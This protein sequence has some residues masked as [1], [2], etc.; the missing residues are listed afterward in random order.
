VALIMRPTDVREATGHRL[1]MA[2]RGPPPAD[3]PATVASD[4]ETGVARMQRAL[5]VEEDRRAGRRARRQEKRE[6]RRR[7]RSPRSAVGLLIGAAVLTVVVVNGAPYWLMLIAIW[8]AVMAGSRLLGSRGEASGEVVDADATT[9]DA[10]MERVDAL[11]D[12]LL[13][14]IRSAP[15]VLREV[16]HRPEETV[17]A[18]RDG[19]HALERRERELRNLLRPE[20]EARLESERDALQRRLAE[21]KDSVT[22]QRLSQALEA[23]ERQRSD[24]SSLQTAASRLEAERT[25]LLYT[26]EGLH[27]QV[28]SVSSTAA[29]GQDAAAAEQLR[30]SLDTLSDEV[31]AVAS[32][33][34]S[35]QA[36][37]PGAVAAPPPETRSS[38]PERSG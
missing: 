15:P 34:E 20:D 5:A 7:E 25:R 33:L 37:D 32:A 30:K 29:A 14:D 13:A 6:R 38:V 26:L 21:E 22:R 28:L 2:R 24:R 35:V 19:V 27:T 1:G 9:V 36:V 31:S 10:R 8:L 12:Q 3:C 11:C 16:V 4:L 17:R 18:L 23:L